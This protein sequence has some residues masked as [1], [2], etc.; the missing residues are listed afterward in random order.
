MAKKNY[1]ILEMGKSW[2]NLF[3]EVTFT[4]CHSGM[5]IVIGYS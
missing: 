1:K 2:E 3:N 5:Q 4:A